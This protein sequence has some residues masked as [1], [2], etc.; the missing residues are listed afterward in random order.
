M[1]IVVSHTWECPRKQQ[2]IV[3]NH[4]WEWP[5]KQQFRLWYAT[6]GSV[7]VTNSRIV[8]H[9]TYESPRNTSYIVYDAKLFMKGGGGRTTRNFKKEHFN[10]QNFTMAN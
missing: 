5:C 8:L 1:G 4:T 3:V 6:R 7:H 2:K 9:H 10:W